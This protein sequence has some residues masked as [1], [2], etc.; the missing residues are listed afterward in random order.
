MFAHRASAYPFIYTRISR[1]LSNR[2]ECYT[3]EQTQI[4]I[5]GFP[6]CANTY[7]TYAFETAQPA[8]LI[9]AHHIH[10]QSQFIVAERYHIPC[11]LLIREPLDCIS[12]LIV[13]QPKYDYA[14]ALKGY[15]F[16]YNNLLKYNNYVVGNFEHV[17]SDYA[18]VI[19]R[20]NQKFGSNFTPYEKT[21]ANEKKV[22]QIVQTQDELIGATD[23]Q[24]RVAYPTE[25]RKAAAAAI[26]TALQKP[27]YAKLLQ[28]CR[29]VYQLMLE[30]K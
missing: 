8:K 26:K 6:R 1:I 7:A 23:Y 12:S 9:M 15:Y 25:E 16:L 24:Q 28:Q 3:S 19:N 5:D 11:I 10:K 20:L 17:L 29:E 2:D 4:V 30:K 18:T 14:V 21:E 13:R 22:K 27:M